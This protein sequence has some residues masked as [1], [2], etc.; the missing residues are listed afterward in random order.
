MIDSSNM[1]N[2]QK[3]A[4]NFFVRQHYNDGNYPKGKEPIPNIRLSPA[5]L[6]NDPVRKKELEDE[7]IAINKWRASNNL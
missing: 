5:D 3:W 1:S 2:L 4:Y 6:T 7:L